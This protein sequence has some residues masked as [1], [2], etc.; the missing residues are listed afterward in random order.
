MIMKMLWS[1]TSCSAR[2]SQWSQ[3]QTGCGAFGQNE[4]GILVDP[5]VALAKRMEMAGMFS[6]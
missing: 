6:N 4:Q 2:V 1:T 5:T 3:G